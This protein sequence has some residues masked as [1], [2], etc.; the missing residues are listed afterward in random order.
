MPTVP[1]RSHFTCSYRE[2]VRNDH[3]PAPLGSCEDEPASV[4]Q[5]EA[6]LRSEIGAVFEGRSTA[7]MLRGRVSVLARLL[8]TS[9]LTPEAALLRVKGIAFSA[10]ISRFPAHERE[11]LSRHEAA[12]VGQQLVTW[13]IESYFA[14]NRLTT[15]AINRTLSVRGAD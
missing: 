11:W 9:G 7:D 1:L 3:Q 12:I 10:S 4:E 15:E 2:S 5:A 8:R 13:C 6:A 14:E